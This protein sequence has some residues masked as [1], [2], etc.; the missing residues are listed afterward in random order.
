M[1]CLLFLNYFQ[2]ILCDVFKLPSTILWL[3]SNLHV[4]FTYIPIISVFL[5]KC[6]MSEDDRP[7]NIFSKITFIIMILLE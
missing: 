3:S 2:L 5:N 1:L 4:L 7:V 6:T